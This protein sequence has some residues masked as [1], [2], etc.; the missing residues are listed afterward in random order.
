MGPSAPENGQMRNK[1]MTPIHARPEIR[2][3]TQTEIGRLE[4]ALGAPTDR[5][6]LVYW[7]SQSIADAVTLASQPTQREV[8][9]GL[10]KIEHEGRAWLDHIEKSNAA[11]FLALRTNLP[12]LRSGV[13]AFCDQA[14]ALAQ[15]VDALVRG[16][17]RVPIG[18]ELF[19]DRMIGIAKHSK[20]LPSTPSRAARKQ[21]NA[22]VRAAGMQNR[23]TAARPAFFDFVVVALRL[24]R[25]VIKTS[26]LPKAKRTAALSQLLFRSEDAINKLIVKL[27][28][29]ISNYRLTPGGFVESSNG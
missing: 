12:E 8:R 6:Y 21:P 19:I 22:K 23:K 26:P 29:R 13:A 15:G 25:T 2:P 24:A 11:P 18:L 9:D 5:T 28:G 20:V 1:D 16:H 7:V 4:K 3:L 17:P 14:A 27:R 10:L